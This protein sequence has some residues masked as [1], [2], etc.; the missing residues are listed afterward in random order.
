M[1]KTKIVVMALLILCLLAGAT[2]SVGNLETLGAATQLSMSQPLTAQQVHALIQSDPSVVILDARG[3]AEYTGALP[4]SVSVGHIPGA[5]NNPDDGNASSQFYRFPEKNRPY[6][7]YCNQVT[8]SHAFNLASLMSAS[9][10]TNVTYMP[11]GVLEWA[12]QGYPFETGQDPGGIIPSVV[13]SSQPPIVATGTATNITNTGAK[14]S[15]SLTSKG[16]AASITVSFEYGT[17]TSYGSTAAGVP[18]TLSSTG[19]FTANLTGLTS[20]Q[21]YHF[22]TKAVGDG[23]VYGNDATFT[24]GTPVTPI[25]GNTT[26]TVASTPVPTGSSSEYS[27]SLRIISSTASGVTVGQLVWCAATTTDFPNL[28]TVGATLTGT[29]DNSAGWW[30]LKAAG[31]IIPPPPTTGTVTGSVASTFVPTGSLNEYALSLKIVNTADSRFTN[32][33]LVWCA[34]TT[35]D[36]PNL[37]TA[38]AT[39]TGTLDN[40]AGWWV[41][42]AAGTIIPPP[43]TTGTVTGL[44]ASTPVPTGSLNEYALSLKI[45]N[46]ADSRFTNGQLVWCAATTTDFPNLLTAGATLTGTLDNSV[47]WWVL[48]K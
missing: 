45:V 1:R 33:Q 39:L 28:L 5:Y 14:V 29:L 21:T 23:T 37:L 11:G 42:K 46:T 26:G 32:G 17:T 10:Y 16:T 2:V 35:T 41:L 48:K 12:A 4:T 15:G 13:S 38:G 36:F 27:F 31:I 43:P 8:C 34:V 6:I 3:N 7:C 25:S 20:G 9:G 22:R 18:S 19:A 40:S 30:V 24:T 44:V 47:G